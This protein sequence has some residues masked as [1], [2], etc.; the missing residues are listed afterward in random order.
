MK[1][2]S[3][4]PASGMRDFLPAELR[5][6]QSVF[7]VVR[8]VY[9]SYGF[10]PLETP[11]MERLETLTGKY[12]EEGDQLMYKVLCRGQK[13]SKALEAGASTSNELAD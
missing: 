12:G 13:L 11:V 4:K 10:E 8:T 7:D 6:R 1:K 9:E 2:L 3:T 5:K